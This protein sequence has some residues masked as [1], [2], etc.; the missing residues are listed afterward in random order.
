MRTPATGSPS[1]SSTRPRSTAIRFSEIVPGA[2]PCWIAF[3]PL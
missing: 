1:M 3:G 2:T